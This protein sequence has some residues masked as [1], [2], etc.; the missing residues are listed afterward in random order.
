MNELLITDSFVIE[1]LKQ[2]RKFVQYQEAARNDEMLKL[3]YCIR[4]GDLS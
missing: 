1:V 3:W 4:P 2:A